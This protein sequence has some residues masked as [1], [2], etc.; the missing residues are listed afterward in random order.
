[1]ATNVGTI[2][3]L[4][5]LRDEFTG[6]LARAT[7]QMERQ[8]AKMQAVG[9]SV[10]NLGSQMTR[11]ITLPI[12]A[13]GGI[14]IK[15]FGDFDAAMAKSVA[16]IR[17]VSD[18]MRTKMSATAIEVS[19]ITKFTAEQAAES[20]F[21]LASAGL[22]VNQA[23]A[24]LPAVA[25]FAQAGMFDMATA[26]TLA[27]DAQS[28][29]GMRVADA[30]E[31][32]KN[33][34]R[35]TDVL[36]EANNIANADVRQFSVALTTEAGAALKSFGIDVEEGVAVLAA[37][38]DQGIKA[39]VAGNGLSRILRMVTS[40]AVEHKEAFKA[41]GIEV[42]NAAG[43]IN[44]L[45][46][47]VEDVENAFR[48][49]SDEQRVSALESL[50]FQAR[51]QGIILP[52]LGT[53]KA[54][55]EYEA[56]LRSAGGA[57]EEV[58]NKQLKTLWSQ[59]ALVRN[60]LTESAI[61]LGQS[62]V[63][64]IVDAGRALAPLI[65]KLAAG[66]KWFTE[67]PAPVRAAAL[68]M[69]AML[70]AAGPLLV[71]VGGMIVVVGSAA[72]AWAALSAALPAIGAAI[73]G[74]VSV[75]TGPA[76]WI[77]AGVALLAT[78]KPFRDF[79]VEFATA[80]IT[81]Y[82]ARVREVV[83][84][85]KEWWAS[86]EDTR[87]Y[88][89]ELAKVIARDVVGWVK[90]AIQFWKDWIV[91]QINLGK[92]VVDLAT[93]FL[94]W[95]GALKVVQTVAGAV[96]GVVR[97]L[98]G[99]IVGLKDKLVEWVNSVGGMG[100]IIATINPAM[101]P[102]LARMSEWSKE[103]AAN[104]AANKNAAAA[105]ASVAA[106]TRAAGEAAAGAK[107]P[108]EAQAAAMRAAAT[109]ALAAAE[110]AEE[111]KAAAKRL[112]DAFRDARSDTAALASGF[113]AL[114]S[115]KSVEFAQALVA[116]MTEFPG[117]SRNSAEGLASLRV[118]ADRAAK[119]FEHL[120]AV[121]QLSLLDPFDYEKA[122]DALAKMPL[123]T[124]QLVKD[125]DRIN[126]LREEGMTPL[127]RQQIYVEETVA[128]MRKHRMTEEEINS[129]L[130]QNAVAA[131]KFVEAAEP[132]H[133]QVMWQDV[134]KGLEGLFRDTTREFLLTGKV[135]WKE[136]GD[137]LKSVLADALADF[138]TR[139]AKTLVT[140]LQQWIAKLIAAKA[141]E[142][143]ANLGGS[144]SVSTGGTGG[145]G[146]VM[147]GASSAGAYGAIAA[148]F[149]F[150]AYKIFKGFTQKASE[151][152][153]IE[154]DAEGKIATAATNSYKRFDAI[155]RALAEMIKNTRAV[156]EEMS[157]SL[158]SFGSVEITQ[159]SAGF[160]VAV[161]GYRERFAS[162]EEAMVAAQALMIRFGEFADSVP[163]LVQSA[164]RATTDLGSLDALRSNIDFAR[165]LLT[166]NME[167]VALAMNDATELFVAQMRRSI[168]MFASSAKTLDV[169]ALTAA[170]GSAILH[171]TN[172]LQAL[173]NQLTGHKESAQETAERQR[174]A[175]NLQRTIMIAQITLLYEEIRARVALLQAQIAG[176]RLLADSGL[177]GGSAHG[178]NQP[179]FAGGP[180]GSGPQVFVKGGGVYQE[181]SRNPTNNPQLAALLQ[182]LDGLARAM[183]GLPPEIGAGGVRGG[184][185]S[186][187]GSGGTRADA[188]EF[189]ASRR[190]AVG[191]M[192]LPS[193]FARQMAALN[194]EYEEQ[195]ANAGRDVKLRAEIIALRTQETALL[196]EEHQKQVQASYD[197]ITGQ[198]NAF[199]TL[200]DRFAGVAKE[201]Q[202]A[203]YAAAKTAEMMRKL[204]DAE[205]EASDVLGRQMLGDLVGGLAQ[206]ITD[207]ALKQEFLT[208]QA[209]IKF[210]L[211]MADY[212]LQFEL[213]KEKGKLTQDEIDLV[214][215]GIDYING[216]M[217][218]FTSGGD[219]GGG[220]TPPPYT[221]SYTGER[222]VWGGWIWTWNGHA[223]VKGNQYVP[224]GGTGG[225]D[226]GGG[227]NPMQQAIEMLARYQ[228]EGL[229]RWHRALNDLNRDFALIRASLGNT[230][231]VAQAY[232][233]AFARLR[234]E[235]LEGL[236]E[237]RD[238]LTSGALGGATVTTQYQ[239]A[240]QR[241]NQLAA[242]VRNGDLSQA[243]DLEAAGRRYIE[244][245]QQMFGTSTMSFVGIRDAI[246]NEI[247]AITGG[248]VGGSVGGNVIGGPEWFSQGT[249]QQVAA[250]NTTASMQKAAT[251]NV[252]TVVDMAS[253][254][255][256][257]IFRSINDGVSQAVALLQ[258]LLTSP[259]STSFA[260]GSEN[261][262]NRRK[263]GDD[264][265]WGSAG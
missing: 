63:P 261:V 16:I 37:F 62:L 10:S 253:H 262:A 251:D 245:A 250:I 150:V 169:G 233:D 101:G 242:A 84:V 228:A 168:E 99:L 231:E 61:A 161:A 216:H 20:Y 194:R 157:L 127:K 2:E 230:P 83:G 102:V 23:V 116:V 98:G 80:V 39:E 156:L 43:K 75:L 44:N 265:R 25:R 219:G 143:T 148:F 34:V 234:A 145:D 52:L 193:D 92:I 240:I 77:A 174:Q 104:A 33:M 108:T 139:W 209:Q 81:N 72:S 257:A 109:A 94:A 179:G 26:T 56:K 126:Q 8:G 96:T 136:A 158:T 159:N 135:N 173:Y 239:A 222:T 232:A 78:W 21:F 88:L 243:D 208:K 30:A 249:E 67:L 132:T 138:A 100:K 22:S 93:K 111:A 190:D 141:A 215:K 218:D 53:S 181:D 177:T 212:K 259:S 59:L 38:A 235:F 124:E 195:L 41:L 103:A 60:R 55:H 58:A 226:T 144:G 119:S 95:S 66:V 260:V 203:G 155:K 28:A 142:R 221:G 178:G 198:T 206:Y 17:G 224:P 184:R 192:K 27:A 115:G 140:W 29:L 217:P 238:E 46:D 86:T 254:R 112:G 40:G 32:L 15:S 117:I 201:V 76:G 137:S 51:I 105:G 120:A 227:S 246:V 229:D 12:A 31:N 160:E 74:V 90:T 172:S 170:T 91:A 69:A 182:V 165:T 236:Q 129:W 57:T 122:L 89:V 186:G 128:W 256:E 18:E 65:D 125:L 152:V 237:F 71:A 263:A 185:R 70:A 123:A 24:A 264:I 153:T 241:Y 68:G 87:G 85:V 244:L 247:N 223:W 189:L 49:M 196:V 149:G 133:L 188:R 134:M 164:V 47:I 121:Q 210:V 36:T 7:M 11:S 50:G 79:V 82:V 162:A 110:G 211:D 175:Y 54:I 200:H 154:T 204:A 14:A 180:T 183:A 118:E 202:G 146:G 151:F 107:G 225:G 3:G 214:Q 207:S 252:A 5:R 45:G 255:E 35:I 42:F 167:Q 163:A 97:T 147:G 73:A 114:H 187:G 258:Q 9:R 4:L 191:D 199:T 248:L 220:D 106:T 213:L 130:K 13:V 1:M 19:R 166:Q 176:M 113:A 64:I 197:D 131:A 171:F 6:V 205:R 48:G